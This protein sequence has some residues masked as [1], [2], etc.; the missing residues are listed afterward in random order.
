MT[1]W[2][3]NNIFMYK[4]P[5]ST[6]LLWSGCTLENDGPNYQQLNEWVCLFE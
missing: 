5:N 4:D 3:G 1:A 2:A 6:E